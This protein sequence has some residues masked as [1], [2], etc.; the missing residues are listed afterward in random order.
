MNKKEF[1]DEFVPTN[2]REEA[3]KEIDKLVGLS[4]MIDGNALSITKSD[5]INLMESPS[6]F[7]DLTEE[8]IKE[9][10]DALMQ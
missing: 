3:V 8:Q 10:N 9:I 2:C 7:I 5:F 4:C 6:V 1:L